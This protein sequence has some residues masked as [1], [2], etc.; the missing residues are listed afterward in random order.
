MIALYWIRAF[1]ST[2]KF[3]LESDEIVVTKGAWWKTKSIV[4]YNRIIN[5][6]I[7]QGPISRALGLEKLSIQTAGFSYP[8]I[9]KSRAS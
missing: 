6:N 3:I 4:P 9:G 7:E 1:H 2:I 5:M 8:D